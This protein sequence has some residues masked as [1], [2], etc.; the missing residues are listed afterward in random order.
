[1]KE[2]KCLRASRSFYVEE[3]RKRK[4]LLKP[5]KSKAKKTNKQRKS[6]RKNQLVT[7]K[8]EIIRKAVKK[9]IARRE[10]KLTLLVLKMLSITSSLI[11]KEALYLK[12]GL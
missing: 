8:Q 7:R 12:T 6:M 4:K 10:Q 2:V 1:M 9:E 5:R 11:L 3:L